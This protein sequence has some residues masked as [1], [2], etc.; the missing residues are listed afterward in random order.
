[1]GALRDWGQGSDTIWFLSKA[2]SLSFFSTLSGTSGGCTTMPEGGSE[3][4]ETKSAEGGARESFPAA[5][6]P[7]LSLENECLGVGRLSGWKEQPG[8]KNDGARLRSVFNSRPVEATA[9]EQGLRRS[10]L[11]GGIQDFLP[12][13]GPC[14]PPIATPPT[15]LGWVSLQTSQ[16]LS[17]GPQATLPWW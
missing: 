9:V 3:W 2:F 1:M 10:Q 11:E 17:P 12:K 7:A 13:E 14:C 15:L 5:V 6:I 16:P 4:G 8:Q